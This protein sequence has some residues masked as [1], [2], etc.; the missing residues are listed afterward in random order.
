MILI[1]FDLLLSPE[2]ET[3]NQITKTT[4]CKGATMPGYIDVQAINNTPYWKPFADQ[5]TITIRAF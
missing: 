4:F 2:V 3:T 5:K 1:Q